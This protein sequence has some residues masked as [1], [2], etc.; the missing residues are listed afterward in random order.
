MRLSA[1]QPELTL[2]RDVIRADD[3]HVDPASTFADQRSVVAAALSELV[4]LGL[5]S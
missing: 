2:P 1:T 5:T 3:G 4:Q